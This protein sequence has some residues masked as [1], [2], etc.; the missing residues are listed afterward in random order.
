[1]LT[2]TSSSIRLFII[3]FSNH[4]RLGC[5]LSFVHINWMYGSDQTF[6]A[7]STLGRLSLML[8]PRLDFQVSF[9]WQKLSFK[10]DW[11]Y[12]YRRWG[13]GLLDFWIPCLNMLA[14][15]TCFNYVGNPHQICYI[16]CAG[17]P[18]LL[19]FPFHLTWI[20]CHKLWYMC[21]DY[22]SVFSH[23][24]SICCTHKCLRCCVCTYKHFNDLI[25]SR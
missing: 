20:L 15:I 2:G 5:E 17:S 10:L 14:V 3:M 22:I 18:C 11:G 19:W 24:S 13:M 25:I 8:P 16:C 23:E 7:Q 12:R 4:L 1:M 6:Q 9:Y 21:C